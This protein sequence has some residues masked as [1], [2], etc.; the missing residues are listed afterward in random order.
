MELSNLNADLSRRVVV[1]TTRS[2]WLASPAAGVWRRPL[3]RAGAESGRATSIVRYDA[4][5][6]FAPH[7]HPGGE[8]ILVLE[9]VFSD[10]HGDYPAGTYLLSPAGSSHAPSSRQGCI[11]F[12]KLC[13]YPGPDRPRIVLDTNQM[14]WQPGP[15]PGIPVKPLYS[16][17][18]YPER[19]WLAK[20][21][22]GARCGRHAHPGGEEVLVLEGTLEDERGRYPR[23][24]WIRNPHL[25]EHEPFTREGCV[26]WVKTGGLY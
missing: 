24:S 22:P 15:A 23:G 7:Q 12:V 11:L 19:T 3:D 6:S 8:E 1:G 9:G 16:Q 4:G 26:I 18:N 2:R 17:A 10:Q 13:Q 20:W 25:S 14:P 21:E 5:A